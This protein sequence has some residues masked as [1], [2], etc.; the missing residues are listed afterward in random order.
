MLVLRPHDVQ[1]ERVGRLS[2]QIIQELMQSDE[3]EVV[4]LSL[5]CFLACSAVNI[6]TK[7]ANVHVSKVE[8][9]Y[10]TVPV[11]GKFE[12][13]FFTLTKEPG[14][15]FESEMKKLDEGLGLEKGRDSDVIAIG[16]RDSAEKMT[17]MTLWKLSKS[18]RVKIVAAGAAISNA[19]ATTL[20][21]THGQ[22]SRDPVHISLIALSSIEPRVAAGHMNPVTAINIYL[23]KGPAKPYDRRHGEIVAEL[24]SK[25]ASFGR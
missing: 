3:M 7:I 22:I 23:E 14:I 10:L 9:D 4:G 15:D 2:E 11:L 13:I 21:I 8:V 25:P 6:A 16:S 18:A 1:R 24:L 12:A 17:T 5:A 20:Q 19:I